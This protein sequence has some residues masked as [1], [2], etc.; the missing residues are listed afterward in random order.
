MF[1]RIKF[2][3]EVTRAKKHEGKACQPMGKDYVTLQAIYSA[4][5]RQS[6]RQRAPT[7]ETCWSLVEVVFDVIGELW[8]VIVWLR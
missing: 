3:I 5:T 4:A 7:S 8:Q 2:F 1:A 6:G